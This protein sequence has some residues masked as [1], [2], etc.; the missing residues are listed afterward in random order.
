MK[1]NIFPYIITLLLSM[2]GMQGRAQGIV[3]YEHNGTQTNIPAAEFD[4]IVPDKA[5]NLKGVVVK[6]NDGSTITV[7]ASKLDSIITYAQAYDERLAYSIPEEYLNKMG[8]HMPI[9]AGNTPPTIEG[10]YSISP[11]IAVFFED[12][13]QAPGKEYSAITI[14]FENQDKQKNTLD[15]SGKGGVTSSAKGAAIIGSGDDFTC[16]FISNGE[17]EGI[18]TKAATLI[19]G[20]KTSNG[21]KNMYY[22]FVLLEKGDDPNNTLMKEGVYRVLKDGDGSSPTTSWANAGIF[23]PEEEPLELP[24]IESR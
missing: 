24:L 19:S 7:S 15:F 23:D 5:A 9:Y 22:G 6:R 12:Y 1:R 17:S 10:A 4:C 16:F 8:K 11:F 14:R 2:V 3:V 21:I 13:A 20:T 18:S